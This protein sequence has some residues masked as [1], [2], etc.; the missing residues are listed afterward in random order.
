MFVDSAGIYY[1]KDF[2]ALARFE[3]NYQGVMESVLWMP[4]GGAGRGKKRAVNNFKLEANTF[5]DYVGEYVFN[6]SFSI[7][8]FERNERYFAQATNQPEFEIIA[9]EKD[10]FSVR[11]ITAMFFSPARPQVRSKRS[12]CCRVAKKLAASATLMPTPIPTLIQTL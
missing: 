11:V 9:D 3:K 1:P 2:D 6:P 10:K 4:G 8:I 12:S 5:I 7:R